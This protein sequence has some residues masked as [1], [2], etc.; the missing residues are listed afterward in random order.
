MSWDERRKAKKAREKAKRSGMG[1]KRKRG[2]AADEETET[3]GDE[4]TGTQCGLASARV[5]P[6]GNSIANSGN[7]A[8]SYAESQSGASDDHN[9]SST[10]GS[11]SS[12]TSSRGRGSGGDSNIRQKILN[13]LMPSSKCEDTPG[14]AGGGAHSYNSAASEPSMRRYFQKE[15]SLVTEKKHFHLPSRIFFQN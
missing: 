8:E 15:D 1:K 13:F 10:S 14:D 5:D 12:S 2:G 6:Q 3:T 7:G 9:V 11:T 4:E